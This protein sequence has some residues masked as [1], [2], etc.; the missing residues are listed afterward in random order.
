MEFHADTVAASVSGGN[1][2]ITALRRFEVADITYNNVF[3]FY[4]EN[5]E[6]GLKPDN[7]YPQHQETM[8]LF[9][10]FHDLR[11]EHGLVQVDAGSFARFNKSR[12]VIK[13]QWA[14][15]PSTDDREKHLRSLNIETPIQYDSAWTLF[16]N[17]EQVQVEMTAHVFE[18]VKYEADVQL[19]NASSFRERYRENM[20]RYQLPA[21][22]KGFFDHR[23]ISKT[24]LR[25][26]E[27]HRSTHASTLNE[28]L[29]DEVLALPDQIR[30]LKS[31]IETLDAIINDKLKVKS[32]EFNGRRLKPDDAPGL[33]SELNK[34]LE[35]AE[36]LLK[37]TDHHVIAWCLKKAQ[38]KGSHETLREKYSEVFITADEC[39]QDR[40]CYNTM[41]E[42]LMPL[43]HAMP[44]DQIPNAIATLKLNE[45]DFRSRLERL[46]NNPES[47]DVISE[48]QR[49]PANEYLAKDWLY[50]I[51]SN[52]VED[53]LERLNRCMFIFYHLS[54]EK[55][56][57]A[58][59]DV[60]TLQ[61]ELAG[62]EESLSVRELS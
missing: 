36:Q 7:I 38:L 33:R 54:S 25:G 2:L 45:V 22:Y 52:Y 29:T 41:R 8:R 6:K 23:A 44:I 4:Q 34:E 31:D 53:A 32:F 61:L 30:G 47:S 57:K 13:D 10:D 39:E 48:D 16:N 12:I 26:I 11:V 18:Q 35:R 40:A 3:Q 19:V 20:Q 62:V 27:N 55:E 43:Y 28:I 24:D 1:H 51:N 46:L 56:F 5:F 14:S 42:S 9:A 37:E 21:I 60:L 58:K 49:R 15:H 17:A 50:F 59:S